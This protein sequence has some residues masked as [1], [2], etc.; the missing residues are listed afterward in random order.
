MVVEGRRRWWSRSSGGWG[1]RD[2]GIAFD[3]WGGVGGVYMIDAVW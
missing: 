3:D 1:G 2:A